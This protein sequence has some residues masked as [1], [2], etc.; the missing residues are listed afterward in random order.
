[1][2]TFV[3]VFK[4]IESEDKT[5]FDNFYSSL[6]A[7]VIINES[8]IDDGFQW[9]YTTIITNI[10]KSLGKGSSWIIDSVT[11]Y[12]ISISK[13]KPLAGSSY[14][15]LLKKLDHKRKGLINIENTDDN[16]C[17]KWSIVRY[18]NPPYRNRERITKADKGFAKKLDFKDRI[19][20]TN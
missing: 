17:F 5:K 8:D 12:T 7:D 3:L 1:M 20:S 16:E 10:Q 2:T 14:I 18:L 15:K 6:K 11:G 13:Y 9:I 19:S 4:E